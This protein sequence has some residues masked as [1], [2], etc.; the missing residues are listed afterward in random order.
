MPHAPQPPPLR[1]ESPAPN[2]DAWWCV[3][4]REPSEIPTLGQWLS[5]EERDR[6]ARFGRPDLRD[7]YVAGR[8]LLRW[9][10][11]HELGGAPASIPIRRGVRGRPY[12]DGAPDFDFNV[13]HTE[14]RAL[15]GVA[16]GRRIGVD[17]ESEDRLANVD[18]LA[19]RVM[20]EDE[21]TQWA[22][23][24][25]PDRRRAFLRH[26]TCKEALAKAT[27]DGLAAPFGRI[28]VTALPHL[29]IASGPEPYRADTWELVA[30]RVPP[31]YIG[32]IALA[33]PR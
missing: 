29:R 33:A 30:V 31:A 23:L 22:G 20:T 10:L 24:A 8:A 19:R 6:A 7:R 32:T 3:L 28:S 13:S 12:V 21:R 4:A 14:S 18:R 16:R 27:G 1:L 11:A 5:G 25:E 26:W 17:L 9:I 2:V 15:V